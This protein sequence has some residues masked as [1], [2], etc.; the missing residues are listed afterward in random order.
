MYE[1]VS[2]LPF[3]FCTFLELTNDQ[4]ERNQSVCLFHKIKLENKWT[5]FDEVFLKCRRI[6]GKNTYWKRISFLGFWNK[7]LSGRFGCKCFC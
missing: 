7:K 3:S 5:D 4:Y 6:K 1:A 2:S